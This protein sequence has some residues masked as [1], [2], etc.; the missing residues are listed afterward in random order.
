[1]SVLQNT[2]IQ[3][4]Y[5]CKLAARQKFLSVAFKCSLFYI[6]TSFGGFCEKNYYPVD[7][8]KNI[9]DEVNYL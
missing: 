7:V 9:G 2:S 8:H 4:L 1:M 3:T 5:N 6:L